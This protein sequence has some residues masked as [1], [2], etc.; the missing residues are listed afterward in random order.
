MNY[1]KDLNGIDEGI[2]RDYERLVAERYLP[3]FSW[4][5]RETSYALKDRNIP[6]VEL[7]SSNFGLNFLQNGNFILDG[8]RVYPGRT[9]EDNLN[10]LL[11]IARVYKKNYDYHHPMQTVM[12]IFFSD[13]CQS[14]RETV[15]SEMDKLKKRL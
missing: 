10:G 14:V 1:E 11:E 12:K 15:K 5:T 3:V 4:I 9:Q 2:K 8:K 7:G 6:S 13:I